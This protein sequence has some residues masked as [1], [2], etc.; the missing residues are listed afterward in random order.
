MPPI[1]VP[2]AI[3]PVGFTSTLAICALCA[4]LIFH[5]ALIA[6]IYSDAIDV[7][8]TIMPLIQLLDAKFA[9]L[10]SQDASPALTP[11]P[12][13][14]ASRMTSILIP[15]TQFVIFAT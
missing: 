7:D 13:P 1:F 3:T 12:V 14:V 10:F 8:P 5:I 4:Q 2:H 11:P 9:L 6:K 15:A